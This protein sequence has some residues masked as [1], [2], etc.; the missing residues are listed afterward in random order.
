VSFDLKRAKC[1]VADWARAEPMVRK[2]YLFG[3]RVRG[4]ARPDS[5]LDVAVELEI[6]ESDDYAL[7]RAKRELTS[8]LQNKIPVRLHLEIYEG[9]RRSPVVHAG[10]SD[11]SVVVYAK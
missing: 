11:C 1:V 3:S 10:L 8:R 2:A 4:N 7:M 6:P 5:D 9:A